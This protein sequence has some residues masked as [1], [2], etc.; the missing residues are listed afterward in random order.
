[1]NFISATV[2]GIKLSN[3]VNQLA[4]SVKNL[5]KSSLRLVFNL[6]KISVIFRGE[7]TEQGLFPYI[8]QFFYL[9]VTG[10]CMWAHITDRNQLI[11]HHSISQFFG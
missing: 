3:L 7:R 1:M 6:F 4:T 2:V 11:M 5:I 8:I 9:N 10:Y